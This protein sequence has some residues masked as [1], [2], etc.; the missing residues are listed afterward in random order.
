VKLNKK[1]KVFFK[2]RGALTREDQLLIPPPPLVPDAIKE[3]V[4]KAY[5]N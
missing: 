2:L 4:L 3:E 1:N 5:K